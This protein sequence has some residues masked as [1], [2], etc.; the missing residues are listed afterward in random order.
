MEI[1]KKYLI[2]YMPKEME[3]AYVNV[4]EQAYLSIHPVVRIRKSN[5]K[6]ILTYQGLCLPM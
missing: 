5:E 2:K 6:Y 4:I 1:E 3:D